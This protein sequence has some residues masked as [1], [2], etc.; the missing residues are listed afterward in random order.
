M[1]RK[2]LHEV[3]RGYSNGTGSGITRIFVT[4]IIFLLGWGGTQ[5]AA[6]IRQRF[7]EI[8]SSITYITQNI[9]PRSE[10]DKFKQEMR[11]KCQ[12]F[13]AHIA[14][15]EYRWELNKKEMQ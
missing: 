6:D 7:G 10:F 9:V 2:K 15:D 11:M 4:I 3:W 12:I 13:D 14:K 8:Q 5:L 1:D